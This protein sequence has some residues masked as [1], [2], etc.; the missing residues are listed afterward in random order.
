MKECDRKPTTE[1]LSTIQI[2]AGHFC[3][4]HKQADNWFSFV[5]LLDIDEMILRFT[6]NT[7]SSSQ[8][9]I[10]SFIL[11][12]FVFTQ[13]ELFSAT[14]ACVSA[15][16]CVCVCGGSFFMIRQEYFIR[17][18][19]VKCARRLLNYIAQTVYLHQFETV[20]MHSRCESCENSFYCPILLFPL[21]HSRI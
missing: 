21:S 16:V 11:G 19:M 1:L 6:Y 12:S 17:M 20:R 3:I 8:D 18:K 4:I 15:C 2:Y 14:L 5:C 13:F 9:K 7:I 10:S